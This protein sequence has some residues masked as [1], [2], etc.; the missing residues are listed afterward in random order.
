M[1]KRF[2]TGIRNV[3]VFHEGSL[4][5]DGTVAE[6]TSLNLSVAL[7]VKISFRQAVWAKAW[8]LIAIT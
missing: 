3:T 5:G 1:E 6:L 7:L 8:P 4:G 2:E